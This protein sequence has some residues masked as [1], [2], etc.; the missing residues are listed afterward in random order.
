GRS[1]SRRA[2]SNISAA[3]FMASPGSARFASKA[4]LDF[5]DAGESGGRERALLYRTDGVFEVLHRRIA[6]ED[7][8][9][10]RLR[11]D[12]ADRGF[13][14]AVGVS[15]ADQ[16]LEA[17]GALDVAAIVRARTDR[18]RRRRAQRMALLGAADGAAGQYPDHDDAHIGGL[19][20]AEQ[21]AVILRR[22]A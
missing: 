22:I 3:R 20:V 17:A 2:T 5:G 21:V 6:D 12:I 14:Q 10:R 19:G 13:D 8:R 9:D 15:L 4:A 16:R 18:R 11:D 1:G 7:G